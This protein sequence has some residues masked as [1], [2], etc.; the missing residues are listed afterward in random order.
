MI[1]EGELRLI[2]SWTTPNS[3]S[4]YSTDD[5]EV[6]VIHNLQNC[7]LTI[8]ILIII[9]CSCII[10]IMKVWDFFSPQNRGYGNKTKIFK[11]STGRHSLVSPEGL[12]C[13]NTC[14]CASCKHR[15]STNQIA[16]FSKLLWILLQLHHFYYSSHHISCWSVQPYWIWWSWIR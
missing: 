3:L 2:S 8:L 14:T 7:C 11:P 13:I 9:Q 1:P 6:G 16:A 10:G 4:S 5:K 12:V 15:C